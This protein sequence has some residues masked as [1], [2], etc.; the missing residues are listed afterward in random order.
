V[1]ERLDHTSGAGQMAAGAWQPP[2][3]ASG[4]A[5]QLKSPLM[6]YIQDLLDI[7]YVAALGV[8][9]LSLVG[10]WLVEI[11]IAKTI[12][13]AA[14]KTKTDLD[15]V[16]VE[17]IRRP[18]F[19]S[20]LIYGLSWSADLLELPEGFDAP[21]I[22]VLETLV[23][24]IWTTAVVRVGTVLL[25]SWSAKARDRSMLQPRTLPVFDMVLKTV[26]IGA[27]IYFM[28][29]A[30][31]I[32][33]T[34]W[35]ASAGIVG[36]AVGFAAKDT[37]ANLFSG[38]FILADGPYK[39]KDWIVLDNN[40]R[41]EVTHIGIR[42]TRVLTN[43][44]VEITVPNAVI[45]NAQVLNECGGP[46]VRQRLKIKFSVAY[47]SDIAQVRKVILDGLADTPNIMS[48]PAPMCRLRELGE[49]SLNFDVLVWIEIPRIR[50]NVIDEVTT[51]I[52]NAL[53]AAQIEM[54]YPKTDVYIRQMPTA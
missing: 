28:F 38:I 48:A 50:D 51:R 29:L 46:H 4:P 45:G 30:W 18:I 24:V 9:L 17:I 22:A 7:P 12:A 34:A 13:V 3:I 35:I 25:Q 26:A 39:V 43:D 40:L 36:I 47:G 49:S 23:I 11:I 44:D 21:I 19:L 27:S 37:L 54:P 10:A 53:N 41:G 15:D 42:S 5:V 52:Y 33:L 2:G 6:E 32:D 20:V 16:I 31:D 1:L 14:A 8:A